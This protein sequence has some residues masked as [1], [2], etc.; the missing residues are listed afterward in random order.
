VCLG[1]VDQSPRGR[2]RRYHL[3]TWRLRIDHGTVAA[4]QKS[5]L[6]PRRRLDCGGSAYGKFATS[7][8]VLLAAIPVTLADPNDNGPTQAR[9]LSSSIVRAN[10]STNGTTAT[11]TAVTSMAA[12]RTFLASVCWP[13]TQAE[14]AIDR[15]F[16]FVGHYAAMRLDVATDFPIAPQVRTSRPC[17]SPSKEQSADP[18]KSILDTWAAQFGSWCGGRCPRGNPSGKNWSEMSHG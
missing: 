12:R 7:S 13:L 8:I 9:P 11:K 16:E 6:P 5:W 4:I 1:C 14:T 15:A 17:R 18:E 2:E 10:S 3:P